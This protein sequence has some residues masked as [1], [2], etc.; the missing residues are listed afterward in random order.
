MYRRCL[1]CGTRWPCSFMGDCVPSFY[2]VH[3]KMLA[4]S[5][6]SGLQ[7]DNTQ[8][9]LR[10]AE[11]WPCLT[12]SDSLQLPAAGLNAECKLILMMLQLWLADGGCHF[13]NPMVWLQYCVR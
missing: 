11:C 12:H 1:R 10:C 4:G 8:L 5:T 13:T 7:L 3:A 6:C 2:R 9:L